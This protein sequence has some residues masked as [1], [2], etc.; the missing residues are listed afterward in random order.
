[1]DQLE[2]NAILF[3]MIKLSLSVFAQRAPHR[4]QYHSQHI[5]DIRSTNVRKV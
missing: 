3:E 5:E 1:M 2:S 4:I